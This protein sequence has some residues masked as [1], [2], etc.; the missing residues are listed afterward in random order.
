MEILISKIDDCGGKGQKQLRN[1]TYR[2]VWT[3]RATKTLVGKFEEIM[4]HSHVNLNS[5][6]TYST[7]WQYIWS[8][9]STFRPEDAKYLQEALPRTG[10]Y[11]LWSTK[12]SIF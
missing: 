11:I 10:K 2:I 4:F 6:N 1:S 8:Y 12:H 3:V 5:K 9:C 7:K